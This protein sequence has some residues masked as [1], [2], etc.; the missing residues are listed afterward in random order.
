MDRRYTLI[1]LVLW[2]TM[3]FAQQPNPRLSQLDVY[4]QKQKENVNV[5][6][7]RQVFAIVSKEASDSYRYEYHKDGADTIKYELAFRYDDNADHQSP[8]REVARFLCS[9]TNGGYYHG[10]IDHQTNKA[11]KAVEIFPLTVSKPTAKTALGQ[12]NSRLKQLEDCL[13][14]QGYEIRYSQ[15]N[16]SMNGGRSIARNW[17]VGSGP[18]GEKLSETAIDSIR[19]AF[20]DLSKEEAATYMYENHKDCADTIEYSVG[21]FDGNNELRPSNTYNRVWFYNAKEQAYFSYHKNCDDG[22]MGNYWH[23]YQSDNPV[24]VKSFDAEAFKKH[25]QP[26]FAVLKSLKGAATYPVY[27]RHDKEYEHLLTSREISLRMGLENGT[28]AGLVTGS[29]YFIPAQYKAET[30]ALYRQLD[31]LTFDYLNRYPEQLHRYNT[32]S[33]LPYVTAPNSLQPF[34]S[35]KL[36]G[37]GYG[38]AIDNYDYYLNCYLMEDGLHILSITSTGEGWMPVEWHKLK[39]WINGK[40][41]YLKGAEQDATRQIVADAVAAKR[42]RIDINTMNTMRYGSRTMSPDFYLE[43]RGDKLHS[44]LPYLGQV[45]VSPT[46][47][48]SIG[49]NF[50]EP[51]LSYKMSIPKSKKYTQ[52]DIDVKTR[53]DN[54]HYVIQLYDS[55]E[56]TIRVR[57]LNRDAISF[58]GTL[59]TSQ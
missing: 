29:H 27:W 48:P 58:D 33:R 17:S 52:I 21:F 30:N 3:A 10:G 47:S 6:S 13:Q 23:G 55:G 35:D 39:S 44:Y 28:H 59:V 19:A 1:C 12:P 31:S 54:Y 22:D 40:K 11:M 14:K 8:I 32:S 34:H 4:L 53:E 56:A 9:G 20:T 49:L 5:D 37:H 24:S 26:A 51:V 46:L 25:I 16:M 43:L 36:L 45:R 18:R 57:S 50:E 15:G 42:W 41:E 7:I 38:Y 2:A